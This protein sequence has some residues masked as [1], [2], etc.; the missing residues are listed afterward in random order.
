VTDYPDLRRYQDAQFGTLAVAGSKPTVL[1][2][3]LMI[4]DTSDVYDEQEWSQWLYN[5]A[6]SV[7]LACPVDLLKVVVP[8]S[9]HDS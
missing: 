8:V 2:D 5:L 4:F 6:H 1:S 3:P 7:L 9:D